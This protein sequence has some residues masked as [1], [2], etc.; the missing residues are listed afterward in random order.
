MIMSSVWEHNADVNLT[1]I[2]LGFRQEHSMSQ[3]LMFAGRLLVSH[4]FIKIQK[5]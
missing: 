3:G 1:M 2:Q 4:G 5:F